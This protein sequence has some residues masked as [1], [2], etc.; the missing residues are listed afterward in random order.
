MSEDTPNVQKPKRTVS[1]IIFSILIFF[2]LMCIGI[3][4]LDSSA[5][6]TAAG[7]KPQPH[8]GSFLAFGISII[9]A[10]VFYNWYTKRNNR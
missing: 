6:D 9:L 8:A 2:A 7:S 10:I 3:A 4:V 1:A 5:L